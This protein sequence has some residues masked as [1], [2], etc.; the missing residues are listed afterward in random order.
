MGSA[1][2]FSSRMRLKKP[3]HPG[4]STFFEGVISIKIF[5]SPFHPSS[6]VAKEFINRFHGAKFRR[7]NQELAAEHALWPEMDK[8][9]LFK[10]HIDDGTKDGYQYSAVVPDGFTYHEFEEL[11]I[12]ERRILETDRFREELFTESQKPQDE[13]D[14][15]GGYAQP[16]EVDLKINY[17]Q[18]KKE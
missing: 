16:S 12:R 7:N 8:P 17:S 10:L 9:A 4:R 18:Y 2:Q 6:V 3:L 11:L 13:E 5:W 14:E 15:E 1:P